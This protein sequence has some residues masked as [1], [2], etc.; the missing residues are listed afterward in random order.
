[1]HDTRKNSTGQGRYPGYDVL[2]KR[3]GPS[4]NEQTRRVIIRRLAIDSAPR[5]FT[6]SEFRT[7][8]AIAGRVVPQPAARPPVP[9][10]ALIDDKLHRGVSDGYRL[11][12]TPRDGEAWR[13]GLRALDAEAQA[14]YGGLFHGLAQGLQDT[15]L[16]RM[17]QGTLDD[18]QW[19]RMAPQDFFRKRMARDIVLAYYAHPTAW[20]EIGWGG[21][22][23]PRGYVRLDFNERD[24]WEAAEVGSG[25]EDSVRRINRHVR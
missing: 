12:G 16:M 25:D 14:A 13:L 23:S 22:A 9:V 18:P 1:M 6:L 4:W 10:A 19:G 24:P 15:L 17:Q 2:T 3:T 5:F 21:P 7:V 8:G 11:A 20:N